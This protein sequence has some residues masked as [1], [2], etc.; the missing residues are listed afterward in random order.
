MQKL[1]LT[2]FRFSEE[3]CIPQAQPKFKTHVALDSS[4]LDVMTDL[5]VVKAET[6]DPKTLL[7]AAEKVMISRGVRSLFVTTDFPCVDG[8]VT[9]ADLM[10]NKPLQVISNRRIKHQE[11]C[12]EDVMT[13]LSGLDIADYD[14]LKNSTVDRVVA[15]FEAL[16][17]T[18]L[19]VVQRAREEG[20]ARIRG[21]ISV[22]QVERQ[23]AMS[24]LAAHMV[25]EPKSF[26]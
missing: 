6:I 15:T 25:P 2:T 19:L 5:A 7:P 10:G 1:T 21:V 3:T 20:P 24:I 18:H 17:C 16:K 12:V 13:P 8:L 11:L 23:L 14:E 9:A 22:T 26:A 4:A